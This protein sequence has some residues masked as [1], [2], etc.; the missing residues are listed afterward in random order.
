MAYSNWGAFVYQG[1]KRR[2]DCEDVPVFGDRSA[3]S[4]APSSVRIFV[5]LLKLKETGKLEISPWWQH[6]HHAVLGDGPVRLCGYKSYPELWVLRNDAPERIDIKWDPWEDDGARE[7][8][9]EIDG[10]RWVAEYGEDPERVE[11]TLIEPD[12]S[13]WT[14]RCGYCIGAGHDDDPDPPDEVE[15]S[16]IGGTP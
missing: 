15:S 3:E 13:T 1:G 9:G 6:A 5:N 8:S 2:R 11:I 7:V 4:S 10:Y 14:A 12:G 16:A